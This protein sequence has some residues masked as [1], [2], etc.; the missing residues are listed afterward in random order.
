MRAKKDKGRK[1]QAKRERK[2]EERERERERERETERQRDRDRQTK[3]TFIDRRKDILTTR[4]GE[5]STDTVTARQSKTGQRKENTKVLTLH[6]GSSL[7]VVENGELPEQ[8][9]GLDLSQSLVIFMH[10]QQTLCKERDNKIILS[11]WWNPSFHLLLKRH[12]T[13]LFNM[14]F[15]SK[16][17]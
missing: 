4:D 16:E 12:V 13:L 8:P 6:R 5:L 14:F 11:L 10:L 9:S 3:K 7:A 2:K 17:K 1:T 15:F